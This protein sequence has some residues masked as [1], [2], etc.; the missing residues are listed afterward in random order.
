VTSE[1]GGGSFPEKAQKQ[2]KAPI[3]QQNLS[4]PSDQ[5]FLRTLNYF[6]ALKSF[7]LYVL[8]ISDIN[9]MIN[10]SS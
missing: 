6:E 5:I 8:L 9:C 1:N 4:L 2:K 7:T 10:Y 3:P